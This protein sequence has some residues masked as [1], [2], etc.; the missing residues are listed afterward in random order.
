V[1]I[2][3]LAHTSFLGHTGYNNH[4]RNFFTH[5]NKYI[6]TR[7]RNFSYC[8]D[9]SYLKPEEM[10]LVIEQEWKD[11]PYKIGTKFVR[12]P[13]AVL[14]NLV[15][16]ESH[17]Y[18]FYDEYDSPLI[19]YNVWEATKQIP[20]YFR[21]ILECD[22]FWAPTE[23][24]IKCTIDQGFPAE[25]TRVVPEGVNGQVFC[26]YTDIDFQDQKRALFEKYDIPLENFTFM[27]FGRWD[28]RKA[29]T[30]ILQAFTKEFEN[31]DRVTLLLSAD[32]PFSTDKLKTTENRLKHYKIQSEK[33]KVLH[34]PPRED[35]VKFLKFGD[36]FLSCSRSEGW[37]LPLMEAMACGTPS[38][39]S[40]WGGQLEFADGISHLVNV[41]KELPPKN[42]FML[43]DGFDI[44]V[45]GEPDFDH[46]CHVMREVYNKYDEAKTKAVKRSKFIRELYTWDNAARKAEEYIIELAKPHVVVPETIENINFMTKHEFTE[47]NCPKMTFSSTRKFDEILVQMKDLDGEILYENWFFDVNPALSY[48][49]SLNIP[50]TQLSG[51]TFEIYD[52]DETLLHYEKKVYV[53]ENPKISFVTSFY[54]A[55]EFIEELASSVFE[56]TMDDW[57]WVVT[58][59]FSEDNTE[60]KVREL[61]KRDRRV[62]YVEQKEKQEIY[63]NPHK[64]AK[65]EIICVIDADD[66]LVPK[67]AEVIAH[68]YDKFQDVNCIHVSG[69][70]YLENFDDHFSFK[71]P[72]YCD[73]TKYNSILEKHSIFLENKSGYERLGYM[74]GVI[75]SYRNPGP[76]FNFND[77]DYQLGKHEDLVKLLRLEEVGTPLYL[78][79]TLYKVRMREKGSNSGT[80]R[81]LGGETEFEKI[82]SQAEARRSVS[83]KHFSRYDSVRE[84][85]YSFLYSDLNEEKTK[86]KISCLGFDCCVEEQ[87][88]VK[89]VYFDHDV[90]FEKVDPD[91]DYVFAIIKTLNDAKLYHDI[92]KDLRKAQV[93]FFFINEDWEPSY[94]QLEDSSNYFKLFSE[95]KEY[96]VSIQPHLWTTYLYKYCTI[97]YNLERP[98]VKLNLG[99][100]NDI[101]A[102]YINIDKYNNTANVD[103]RCDIGDLSA[104]EDDSVDEIYT[105][106]VFEHIGI[107]DIYGV[108]EEWRRVLRMNG[109]LI[110]RI[111]NLEFEVRKWLDAPD[112][113]KWIEVGGIFGSQSHEG[114]AHFC[115]FNPGSLKAFIERFSFEVVELREQNSGYGEEIYMHAKK[116][117]KQGG[118]K[119]SYISHFVDGPFVEIRGEESKDFFLVDFLDPDNNSSVHQELME[120]NHWTRPHRKYYT[121]WLIKI[122]RNGILD[123]EH[124]FG[125]EGKRVLISFD[126]K[127]LGDTIA[128]F[129]AVEEFR[130]KHNCEVHVSTFWNNLFQRC[131]EY[132]NLKFVRPGKVVQN[133]YA[134]YMVGCFDGDH[135]KNKTDW[136]LVPLQQV[137]FDFLGLEYKEVVP[138]IFAPPKYDRKITDKPYV[139]ISEFSTFQCKFWN[140]PGGWQEIVDYLNS[141]GYDVVVVSKE[142]TKLKNIIDQTDRVMKKTLNTIKNSEFFIG[143]SA[144]PSW[145][146][147]ALKKPVILI[148]GYS[149]KWGEFKTKIQRVINEDVC[150]GCFNDPT[151]PLER[152]NWNWCPRQSGTHKQ[153]EC[154]KTITPD[155][156]KKAIDNIIQKKYTQI[157]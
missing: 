105:A 66:T 126:T 132:R 45:W 73:M 142:E 10:A 115:G 28:Y 143:V 112:E 130:K 39:A 125:L 141:L 33:I 36:V 144:G 140:Y 76:D 107:N 44:G 11:E 70:F 129:P 122:R 90:K 78:N 136:R 12:D 60:T 110:I 20:Q 98:L 149:A 134:S 119:A 104:F 113:K 74:F 5:L 41:P 47:T 43:G 30:E 106:H 89:E 49:M 32:N 96:L 67:T 23:W 154:S 17:H 61:V 1:K 58:D 22:Q 123:Y 120:I 16:N 128:W 65:G 42:V 24:Q 151:L 139:A 145:L 15:L 59:D 102:G 146:A 109:D 155:M 14:V 46:L 157:G 21:R 101:K 94:Y 84:R 87:M 6:P 100:G 79:R 26:P 29:T 111:P 31:D 25:K 118:G 57:E 133:L 18:F 114:N 75:R 131:D 54:N 4:S 127:S 63:W 99:C 137:A 88:I 50:Q 34:F 35:Y 7:V 121:N 135:H 13:N 3:V 48:W 55:E 116:R 53:S 147:W 150:H 2:Q 93:V 95:C 97:I 92:T 51:V 62:R 38:I 37:N 52:K 85:L 103:M 148:S 82:K 56:Q 108:V 8:D 19:F 138:S 40:N 124:Q 71:N 72:S 27:I 86:K 117:E 152:G 77:G 83:Y 9:L 64:Y 69:N 91:T 153:F 68:F 156:V 81:D 80:W